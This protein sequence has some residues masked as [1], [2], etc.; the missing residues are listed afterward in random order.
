MTK[1]A[2][3]LGIHRSS[4]VQLNQQAQIDAGQ[5]PGGA[6]TTEEKKELAR[7]AARIAL[8]A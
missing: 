7:S 6:L 3:D 4:L 5:G 1:V 8:F 2:R